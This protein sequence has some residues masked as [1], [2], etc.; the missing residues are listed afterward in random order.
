VGLRK[1]IIIGNMNTKEGKMIWLVAVEYKGVPD[2]TDSQIGPLTSLYRS[3][4]Q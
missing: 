1:D 4:S 2:S 3:S